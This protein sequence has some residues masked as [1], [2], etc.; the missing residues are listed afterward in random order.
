[1]RSGSSVA[2]RTFAALER[3]FHAI[4]WYVIAYSIAKPTGDVTDG[5]HDFTFP[6]R[7]VT[8]EQRGLQAGLI[9]LQVLMLLKFVSATCPERLNPRLLQGEGRGLPSVIEGARGLSDVT[10]L[11]AAFMLESDLSSGANLVELSNTNQNMLIGLLLA[12]NITMA[13]SSAL[14]FCLLTCGIT[15]QQPAP[16]RGVGIAAELT[17]FSASLLCVGVLCNVLSSQSMK[18]EVSSEFGFVKQVREGCYDRMSPSGD[19]GACIKTGD[20]VSAGLAGTLHIASMILQFCSICRAFNALADGRN[21]GA[22]GVPLLS[23]EVGRLQAALQT[24]RQQTRQLRQRIEAESTMGSVDLT[25]LSPGCREYAHGLAAFNAAINFNARLEAAVQ[26]GLTDSENAQLQEFNGPI[27]LCTTSIPVRLN[28]DTTNGVY[29][30]SMLVG[31][32]NRSV[33]ADA[34]PH[35]TTG[36]VH[37][38]ADIVAALDVHDRLLELLKRIESGSLSERQAAERQVDVE[39]GAAHTESPGEFDLFSG[40]CQRF[41]RRLQVLKPFAEVIVELDLNE[42]E[43][44]LLKK[45]YCC[46]ISSNPINIPVRVSGKEAV[47]DLRSLK[48]R[49]IQNPTNPFTGQPYTVDDVKPAIDIFVQQVAF[50]SVVEKRLESEYSSS[51]ALNAC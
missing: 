15:R 13:I 23:A 31:W 20:V 9:G 26:A 50:L 7:D 16:G 29:E 12:G 21:T 48:D 33:N 34:F 24:E 28:G 49:M 32:A 51:S 45:S 5:Y 43:N 4:L 37:Q 3:I 40:E 27:S 6:D 39:A 46:K 47:Y 25:R 18:P 17:T 11:G 10:F 14:T 44:A 22:G 42:G 41:A 35:T 2:G 1:M 19:L 36:I 38:N 30:L 8:A